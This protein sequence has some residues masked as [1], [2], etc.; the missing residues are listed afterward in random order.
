VR[1]VIHLS[2]PKSV[3]QYYQEA[4]RAGRDGL[5]ADCVLLWQKKDLG[6]HAYFIGQIEDSAERARAWQRYREMERFVES[7]DCRQ[8]HV[9]RHFG[10][11]PK[12][13]RCEHCDSCA[14]VPPWLEM[15]EPKSRRR[16]RVAKNLLLDL[17]TAGEVRPTVTLSVPE[18]Q[19]R[20]YLREWRRNVARD[21]GVAA[22]VVLHDSA[23]DALCAA[24]PLTPGELRGISGFGDKKVER[25]GKEVLAAL[26]RFQ[27]GARAS[28][29]WHAKASRPAEETLQLLAEGRSFEEIAQIRG[30]KVSS[31]ESL[32][33][34]LIEAGDTEFRPEWLP[35][36]TYARIASAIQ[37]FGKERLKP[38]KEALP[39]S[40]S[41]GQIRLVAAH[42]RRKDA[43]K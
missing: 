42:L 40:I 35:A 22:F 18:A 37:Q 2:L 10:E 6:L 4:G 9:C 12:W 5:P 39:E 20:E 36:E 19:L 15:E 14:G 24:K 31:V 25:Y 41:Y 34:D 21:M 3:E 26:Q 43:G 29:D 7:R 17:P 38:V 27:E 28:T 32:V 11:Q 33:A 13:E 23:L 16:R 8:R 30:R 1:A